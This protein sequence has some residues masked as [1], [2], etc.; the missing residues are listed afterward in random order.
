MSEV[1]AYTAAQSVKSTMC[2]N[3]PVVSPLKMNFCFDEPK[4]IGVLSVSKVGLLG[5]SLLPFTNVPCV[6]TAAKL[7]MPDP[8][9]KKDAGI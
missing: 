6:C 2:C 7:Q 5:G 9:R 8:Q 1:V 4:V 3:S